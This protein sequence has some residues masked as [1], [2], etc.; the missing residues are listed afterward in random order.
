MRL[1]D[2]FA[3]QALTALIQRDTA[4]A[5]HEISEDDGKPSPPCFYGDA[6]AYIELSKEAY[7]IAWEMVRARDEYWPNSILNQPPENNS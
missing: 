3:A 6:A 4:I 1:M 2:Y 7:C 5:I